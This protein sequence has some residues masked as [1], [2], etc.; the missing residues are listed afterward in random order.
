MFSDHNGIR[1][2]IQRK[3]PKYL[4]IEQYTSRI[5]EVSRKNLKIFKLWKAAQTVHRET[6]AG[7]KCIY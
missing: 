7:L 2:E 4:E 3:I 6:S 1:A 5:K